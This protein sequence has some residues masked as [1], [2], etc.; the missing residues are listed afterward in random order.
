MAY[1]HDHGIVHRD[2]K[3]ANL[4]MEEGIVKIGDYGLA[5]LI[6]PSQGTEHSESIGTCH[7]MAPEIASGKYNKPIDIYAMGVIL[8]E[9][10]TGPGAVRG[11]DGQR[12]VDEAPDRAAGRL[13]AAR[14]VSDDRR[15]GPGQGPQPSISRV[16]DLL[17]AR[18]RPQTHRRSGS[19][20]MARSR[21]ARAAIP[22]RDDRTGRAAPDDVLRI[23]AEEP[24]FYIGPDTAPPRSQ[25]RNVIGQRIRANW[26]ALRRPRGNRPPSSPPRNQGVPP[27]AMPLADRVVRRASAPRPQAKQTVRRVAAAPRAARLWR[28][29]GFVPLSSPARCSGLHRFWRSW[30][31][32]RPRFWASMWPAN[33]SNW[34]FFMEWRSWAHG[35]HSFPTS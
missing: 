7:Y 17:P 18:G 31:F 6:T 21:A 26:E 34:P 8:Y 4:F 28:A 19:S 35:Q 30:R 33:L 32:P 27:G 13:D 24:V 20:A 3:P 23:E 1:L 16:Y 14:A 22:P 15:Q 10:L 29:G 11:R 9:M 25:V 5:K 2:L 12:G